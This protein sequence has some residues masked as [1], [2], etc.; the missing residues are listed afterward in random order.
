MKPSGT[1]TFS[2]THPEM[3]WEGY[4]MSCR[5]SFYL[6]GESDIHHHR[7]WQY[8]EAMDR[9]GLRLSA[10]RQVPVTD[11]IRKYLTSESF[12]RVRGRYQIAIFQATKKESV[13]PAALPDATQRR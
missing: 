9:A 4:E 5:V 13:E 12:Q 7:F 11:K 2:V 8:F 3:D 10:F 6:A 1:I